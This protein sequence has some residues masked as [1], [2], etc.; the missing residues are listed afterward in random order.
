MSIGYSDEEIKQ[1][2]EIRE[3]LVKLIFDKHEE[4]ENLRAMLS[5]VDKM[6]KSGSFKT[7][8]NLDSYPIRSGG[9][10]NQLTHDMHPDISNRQVYKQTVVSS[11][12]E[13]QDNKPPPDINRDLSTQNTTNAD[14]SRSQIIES[15][16]LHRMRDNLLL[17]KADFT[18]DFVE[19]VPADGILLN[20][21]TAPF[22]SFFLGRILEG[23]KV[24]DGEKIRQSKL[25]E[26][27]SLTYTVEEDKNNIIHKIR[28]DNYREKDRLSEIFNTCAWVFSRMLEKSS[29]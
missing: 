7:A 29:K 20:A 26:S 8:S 3:W 23:M 17:A 15:K 5:L 27:E 21:N 25:R 9:S 4:I 1:A 2:A 12:A 13:S 24:K 14:H 19:I 28:I 22:K 10:A 11:A 18:L 16:E 6:L